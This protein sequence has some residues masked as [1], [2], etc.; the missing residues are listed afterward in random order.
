MTRRW[1]NRSA[2]EIASRKA[3][4]RANEVGQFYTPQQISDILSAIVT[5]DGQEPKTGMK[6]R[7]E[8]VMDILRG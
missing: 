5:L 6:K 8:S 2:A 3:A 1:A 7:L 4:R